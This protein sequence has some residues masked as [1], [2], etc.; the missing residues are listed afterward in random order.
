MVDCL[1]WHLWPR[2]KRLAFPRA[3]SWRRVAEQVGWFFMHHRC[4]HVVHWVQYVGIYHVHAL[5]LIQ[6][7]LPDP[8]IPYILFVAY[9]SMP[10]GRH[11]STWPTWFSDVQ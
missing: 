4:T 8:W 9:T 3:D 5:E 1:Y 6:T 11:V 10:C 7:S 2:Q